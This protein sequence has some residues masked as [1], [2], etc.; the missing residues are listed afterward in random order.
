M[1]RA[2]TTLQPISDILQL[3][4]IYTASWHWN[5][6]IYFFFIRNAQFSVDWLYDID[7][8]YSVPIWIFSSHLCSKFY[9]ERTKKKLKFNKAPH[10]ITELE[11]KNKNISIPFHFLKIYIYTAAWNRHKK[12]QNFLIHWCNKNHFP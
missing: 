11:L 4:L 5:F 3:I 9:L 2:S 12:S 1:I 7:W 6:F 8:I 10:K